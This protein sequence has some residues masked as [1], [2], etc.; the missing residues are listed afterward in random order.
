MGKDY[1]LETVVRG[2]TA[3]KGRPLTPKEHAKLVQQTN[4]MAE[5]EKQLADNSAGVEERE[6][7]A[8]LDAAIEEIKEEVKERTRR[9]ARQWSG[10]DPA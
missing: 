2:V 1:S 9:A 8:A 10:H 4:R 3:A 7:E 6:R 5:L